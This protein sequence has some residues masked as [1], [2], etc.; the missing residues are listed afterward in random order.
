MDI[1]DM[2]ILSKLLN[3]CR[4]SDRQIGMELGIS[5]GAVGI[6]I[7]KM[8]KL[9]VIEKFCLKV[10]PPL[11]GLNMFYIV[12]NTQNQK[13]IIR[14]VK[15]AGM[16]F[17]IVPCVGGNTVIGVV[18]KEEMEQK[19]VL[20]KKLMQDVRV[21][22]VFEAN[23]TRISHNLTR[24]DLEILNQLIENPRK[25]IEQLSKDTKLSTKTIN[26]GLEKLQNNELI[27]FTLIFDPSKIEGFLCYAVV[28]I[29]QEDIPQML[30]K[31]E[32]EFSEDYLMT[33]FLAKNQIVLFLY[34]ESI[35]KMDVMTE[36]VAKVEGIITTELFIPKKIDMPS[37]W[38]EKTL[39]TLTK[40]QR[41]HISQAN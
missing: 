37:M 8:E 2:K 15:L 7:S 24:T 1:L 39:E 4:K 27:Q 41:L 28:A 6:R 3:N 13:E 25:K 31:F 12:V 11:L 5:G 33:P 14:N 23:N 35:F 26:R 32:K 9:G 40:S 18:V 34:S 38:L 10:E 29:T 19:I 16:P 36:R 22:S 20:L 30:K 17:T 21:M